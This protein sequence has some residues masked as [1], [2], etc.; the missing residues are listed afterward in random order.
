MKNGVTSMFRISQSSIVPKIDQIYAVILKI[1]AFECSGCAWFC[2]WKTELILLLGGA[3]FVINLFNTEL[4]DVFRIKQC[5][6]LPK[7][8]KSVQMF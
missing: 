7:S 3:T 5:W 8:C 4:W 2:K 1:L 6:I